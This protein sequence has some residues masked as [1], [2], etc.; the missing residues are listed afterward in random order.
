MRTE[1]ADILARVISPW[2][3]KS[4]AIM[5]SSGDLKLSNIDHFGAG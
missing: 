1:K 4:P 5:P 3:I 2:G